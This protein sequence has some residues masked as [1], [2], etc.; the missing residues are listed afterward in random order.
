MCP[1]N[2]YFSQISDVVFPHPFRQKKFGQQSLED[3]NWATT[4]HQNTYGIQI[5]TEVH[6]SDVDD[7][8]MWLLE[9]EFRPHAS[10]HHASG[11]Q[12]PCFW[13]LQDIRMFEDAPDYILTVHKWVGCQVRVKRWA[14]IQQPT[15]FPSTILLLFVKIGLDGGIISGW[16][17][18]GNIRLSLHSY[19]W[20]G[21]S[22]TGGSQRE[23]VEHKWRPTSC[24]DFMNA[25]CAHH[26]WCLRMPQQ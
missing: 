14:K 8:A 15:G 16:L 12:E 21:P 3:C 1:T 4:I 9:D 25:H 20:S 6:P 19:G 24:S 7:D 18:A 26:F 22:D 13:R 5:W 23:W 10:I 11:L 17:I 2:Y